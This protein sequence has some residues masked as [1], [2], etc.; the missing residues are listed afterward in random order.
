MVLE[1]VG[2]V[3]VVDDDVD[4]LTAM[5]LLLKS[6]AEFIHTES[7]PNN[8]PARMRDTQY[9]VILLDMNFSKDT[10]TGSEGFHWLEKIIE[11]DPSAVVIMIT[12][13]GDVDIAVKAIKDGAVDFVLKPWQNE[14]LVATVNTAIRLKASRSEVSS[15]KNQ[16]KQLSDDLE[17]GFK[18]IVGES[19]GMLKAYSIINKVAETNA[20]VLILGES[21]TGKELF[22]RALHRKSIRKEN[23]FISVDMGAISETLFES[24]LFGHKRGAFTDAKN[25]RSGRF[26]VASGGTLFLDEIG[27]LSLGSQSKLLSALENR[28]ITRVGSNRQRAIDIRLVCATNM[29]LYDMVKNKEFRQDLLYRINTV[30][31]SLPPL[32]ERQEDIPKLIEH[33]LDYFASKYKRGSLKVNSAAMKKLKRY[34]WPGNIRELKHA[35][36]RAVIMCDKNVLQPSDF[37]FSTQDNSLDSFA[38]DSYNLDDVER[39]VVTKA[40]QKH[41]GNISHAAEELGLTRTSLYRRI[42]KY[43][44]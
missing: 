27:N 6:H 31:I 36:E 23:V 44:L 1:K 5:R 34:S 30:E 26:E 40:I 19:P 16:Q 21:G 32:R 4:I 39:A 24:E 41:S 38:F 17:T 25:D 20:N 29:S 42:E 28:F 3:L 9:D 12:A 8:I 33:Y 43:G 35:V 13:Y 14:K 18:D 11:I 10:I 37:F 7:N 22:A 15:L 2:K